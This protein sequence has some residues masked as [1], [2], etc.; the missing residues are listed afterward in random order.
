M[1]ETAVVVLVPAADPAFMPLRRVHD[2]SGAEGLGCHVTIMSPF[3]DAA[4]IDESTLVRLRSALAATAPFTVRLDGLARFT[5]GMPALYAT[6]DPTEPFIALTRAVSAEFGLEPYGG[7]HEE[8]VPHLTIGVS[9]DP[10]VLDRIAPIAATALPLSSE[11][12]AVDVVVHEPAG[13][14]TADSISLG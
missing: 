2:P 8:I 9:D 11:I 1:T 3:L 10:A 4:D 12:D 6:V 7:I 13:W 14:R 5:E